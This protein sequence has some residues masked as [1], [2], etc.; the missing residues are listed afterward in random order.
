MTL[1]NDL[2]GPNFINDENEELRPHVIRIATEYDGERDA[3]IYGRKPRWVVAW[4]VAAFIVS[5]A[6]CVMFVLW[7]H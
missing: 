6:A 1:L 3:Q 5:V 7:P 4:T 2:F